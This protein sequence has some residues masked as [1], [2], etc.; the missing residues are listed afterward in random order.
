MRIDAAMVGVACGCCELAV[1][2]TIIFL[3]GLFP[4]LGGLTQDQPG[5]G[6][7]Q[8]AENGKTTANS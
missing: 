8:P 4:T 3:V 6:K 5:R 2:P 1:T 7:V